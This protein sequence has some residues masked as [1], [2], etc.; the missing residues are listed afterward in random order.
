MAQK[1]FKHFPTIDFDVKN[2]GNLIQAKD[3]FRN[4]RVS[5]DAEDAIIG[6]EYYYI[7]DQDRPDVLASKLYGDATLYWLFWMVN[8]QF[9]T[10]NDWPKSQSILDK[11]I[12]R[13]YSGKALVANQQSDIVSSSDSKFLQGEKV[14]GSTS[15]ALGFVTKIDPTNK[16]V[17]LNDVQGVFQDGETVTGSQSTKSFT[18]SSVRNFSDSPH[19]Y[20]NSDGNKTTSETTTMVTN[21]DYEQTFNDSKRSI[22]YI[23]TSMIPQLLREFKSMIRE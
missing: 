7:N 10:Y 9:A 6:Y 11:F 4:I 19:H 1:Y 5:S 13:K 15:S 12:N 14:V 20:V 17:I 3:I 22:K 8:D 23:K 16:Q 2:D 18:I 21:R